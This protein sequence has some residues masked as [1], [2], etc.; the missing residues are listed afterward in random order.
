M[1]LYQIIKREM[2]EIFLQDP[3]RLIFVF[4]AV[5]LYLF[6]FGALYEPGVVKHIPA[7]I[8]DEDQSHLSRELIQNLADSESFDFVCE[9]SSQEEMAQLLGNKKAYMALL[10][11]R[12]FSQQIAAGRSTTILYT[13]NG[14]NLVFAN[15]T[16]ISAQDIV[17]GFSDKIASRYAALRLNQDERLLE[18]K[19]APV[20][21][22]LRILNNPTQTYLLFFSIG[23]SMTAFEQGMF[24]AIGASVHYDF[25]HQAELAATSIYKLLFGKLLLHWLFSMLAFAGFLFLASVW[26]IPVKAS[27]SELFLLGGAFC[28]AVLLLGLLAATFF[29]TELKFV[30]ISLLYVVPA[31]ILSGYTWPLESMPIYIQVL[32]KSFF[33]LTWMANAMRELLLSGVTGNIAENVSVLL[34]M[35]TSC[36]LF[37]PRMFQCGLQ[38]N[39]IKH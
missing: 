10:I 31:F 1:T 16:A 25:K 7:L 8:Y 27:W 19:I 26:D 3:R 9:T 38:K 5:L 11:P 2:R 4:G 21:Y 30:K 20:N 32:A 6:L 24:F 39:L 34:G 23:L 37:T 12:D 33:P 18:K 35:G 14:G 15:T 28:F 13:V 29:S 36:L 17:N 22:T